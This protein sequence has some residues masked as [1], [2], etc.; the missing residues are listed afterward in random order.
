MK[1]MEDILM[2]HPTS[3]TQDQVLYNKLALGEDPTTTTTTPPPSPPPPSKKNINMKN[4]GVVSPDHL[5]MI[6]YTIFVKKTLHVGKLRRQR[7]RYSNQVVSLVVVLVYY[8]VN[9]HYLTT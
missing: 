4:K 9:F 6:Q 7:K 1:S 5:L 8:K 3:L 2:D